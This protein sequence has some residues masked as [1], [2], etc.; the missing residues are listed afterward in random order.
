MDL[1]DQAFQTGARPRQ[2]HW[3][4]GKGKGYLEG[5]GDTDTRSS[6]LPDRC[7]RYVDL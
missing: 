1:R 7:T 3:R 5:D 4:E 2:P 6:R